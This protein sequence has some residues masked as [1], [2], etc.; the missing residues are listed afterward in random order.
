MPLISRLKVRRG[1]I[2][3]NIRPVPCQAAAFPALCGASILGAEFF[4]HY[5]VMCCRIFLTEM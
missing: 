2:G 1:L 3:G 5:T 4:Q